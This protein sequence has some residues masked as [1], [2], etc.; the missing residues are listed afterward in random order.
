MENSCRKNLKQSSKKWVIA[1]CYPKFRRN[2][3]LRSTNADLYHYAGNNPVRYI[4]PDGMDIT[5]KYDCIKNSNYYLQYEKAINYLQTSTKSSI[6][7]T[8]LTDLRDPSVNITIVA[9]SS[10]DSYREDIIRWNPL[11]TV[12]NPKTLIYNSPAIMLM[13]EFIHAWEDNTENGKTA[14][15]EFL[16]KYKS[17][18]DKSYDKNID[19]FQ[20]MKFSRERLYK[21]SFAVYFERIIAEDLGEEA[22]RT[23]YFDVDRPIDVK[24]VLEAGRYGE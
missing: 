17:K 20:K 5:L 21:E 19:F 18:I 12:Y 24:D 4:D 13:H 16:K 11:L 8:I 15:T 10:A 3:C 1:S 14:Y 7:K 22:A 2:L 6:V 23:Y 9:T